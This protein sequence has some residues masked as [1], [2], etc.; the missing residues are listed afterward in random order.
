VKKIYSLYYCSIALLFTLSGVLITKLLVQKLW[1]R[2]EDYV[3]TKSAKACRR[4]WGKRNACRSKSTQFIAVSL[5]QLIN[6]LLHIWKKQF[7]GW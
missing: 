5:I 4:W 1:L 7:R 6:V 2:T 3:D